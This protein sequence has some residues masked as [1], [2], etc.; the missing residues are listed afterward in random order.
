MKA[1]ALALREFPRFNASYVD[2]R[3]E[4]YSR[5][6]VGIAVAMDDALLVPV[7]TDADRKSARRDRRRDA[8]ARR[9]RAQPLTPAR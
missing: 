6:N 4:R 5:V 1:A 3:I 7:V 9:G 8:A 2:G